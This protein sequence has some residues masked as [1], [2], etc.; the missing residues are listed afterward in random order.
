M[1]TTDQ[2]GNIAE[3]A[4]AA[5]AVKL[6][7]D[8]YRPIGEGGRY[9]LIF[10]LEAQL[11]RV[12]CKWAARSGDI[13]SVRCYSCRR[14][15]GGIANRRYTE[16]EVDALAAY[17]A[18]LDKCYLLPVGLW[19]VRRRVH[20]RLAPARNNQTRKINWASDFEFAATL[21]RFEG[22]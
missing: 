19:A 20:L 13:V 18:D 22:P 12:Q 2:K 8:V 5:A 21:S 7:I 1:L 11:L 4:I 6:G 16:A 10:D 14:T 9:D 15:A 3:M 17:C